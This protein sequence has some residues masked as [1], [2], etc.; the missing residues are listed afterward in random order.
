MRTFCPV[1]FFL[2]LQLLSGSAVAAQVK[3]TGKVAGPDRQGVADIRVG[4]WP[5]TSLSLAGAPPHLAAPTAKDGLFA[6]NLPAEGEYYLVAQGGGWFSFYGRNPVRVTAEGLSEIH[7]GLVREQEPAFA[8]DRFQQE[9]VIGQVLLNGKPVAD[10]LVYVYLDPSGRFK[11]MGYGILGPTD[12]EGMF[13]SPLMPGSYYFLV[14]KRQQP[15]AVGPLQAGDL[16]GYWHGNPLRIEPGK[17]SRIAISLLEVPG[18]VDELQGSL[19]GRNS[20]EGRVLDKN[21][22]PVAG[23]RVLLYEDPQMLNRPLFVSQPTDADGRYVLSFPYEGRFYV[24]ARSTIGGAPEPGE[25]VG[26]FAG[27]PDF[28]IRVEAGAHLKDIDIRV[29]EMW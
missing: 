22:K 19:F 24:G 28:T 8:Q 18:K 16:I 6:L 26:A 25:L 7:L 11:G 21:G 14:R 20:I 17:P 13:S 4:A 3:V 29:E 10:A 23:M 2:V 9:G 5:V 12:A 1:V 27:T 15:T